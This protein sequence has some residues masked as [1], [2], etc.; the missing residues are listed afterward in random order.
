MSQRGLRQSLAHHEDQ[1]LAHANRAANRIDRAVFSIWKRILDVMRE[2]GGYVTVQ[3][4][5]LAAMND[6]PRELVGVSHSFV[7]VLAGSRKN[8]AKAIAANISPRA[9]RRLLRERSLIEDE[10]AGAT[11]NAIV[12]AILP[13][14]QSSEV[15]RI[16]YATDWPR[17][18]QTLSRLAPPETIAAQVAQGISQGE[19]PAQVARRIKPVLQG[20]QSSARRVARTEGIR[21][22]HEAQ[23]SVYEG[24]GDMIEGYRVNAV[25]KTE[26]SRPEH[27]KR[28]GTVYYRNPKPGQLGFDKM[29]RPPLEADGSVA[30]NCRCWLEP[31]LAAAYAA[32]DSPAT[33]TALAPQ[34][35]PNQEPQ[36]SNADKVAGEQKRQDTTNPDPVLTASGKPAKLNK[37]RGFP[38]NPALPDASRPALTDQEKI[39]LQQYS[40]G[41]Q[42]KQINEAIRDGKPVPDKFA[43]T[44]RELEAAMSKVPTFDR[45]AKVR[46]AIRGLNK[47]Q[48]Q[49][50]VGQFEE[51]AKS[52]E[53]V[54]LEGYQST[55][56]SM[57]GGAGFSGPVE[58]MI[59]AN[60]GLD[61]NP[62]AYNDERELLLPSGEQYEV[63]GIEKH[64]GKHTVYLR[65]MP[66][67]S[68]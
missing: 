20:V 6:L 39:A 48:A 36:A 35:T 3:R 16:V 21:I 52:G 53:P 18:I 51:A 68:P 28:S 26:H 55:T 64:N 4:G 23:M 34:Q 9:A 56:T 7:Q 41:G 42:F 17:R 54:T 47:T 44:Q 38:P 62:V 43:A 12:G 22:A 65:Q 25:P 58:L 5:V 33:P 61:V 19:T 14:I 46:R 8:A 66:K 27:L 67:R 45:P 63:I 10:S 60:R 32:S 49:E 31:V 11:L 40:G 30:H 13:D 2:G 24:L 29:P 15:Y 37:N 1:L 50:L 57:V 59:E